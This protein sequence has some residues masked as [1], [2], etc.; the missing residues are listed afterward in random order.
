MSRSSDRIWE[1]VLTIIKPQISE[2]SFTT[3]FDPLRPLEI[4]NKTLTLEIP[5]KFFS[6]WIDEHYH[7]IIYDALEDVVDSDVRIKYYIRSSNGQSKG[8]GNGNI[9]IKTD[10]AERPILPQ[11]KEYF[12]QK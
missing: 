6:E 4:E 3:W 7:D 10:S 12:M 8:N 1:K 11:Q 5:N 9:G 2:Q